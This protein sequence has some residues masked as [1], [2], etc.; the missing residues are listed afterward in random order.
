MQRASRNSVRICGKTGL[1][2]L[3]EENADDEDEKAYCL[4]GL[5]SRNYFI[6]E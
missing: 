6:K 2:F 4:L 3:T 1:Y 5:Q